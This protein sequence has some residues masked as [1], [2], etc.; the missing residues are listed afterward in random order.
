MSKILIYFPVVFFYSL[1]LA[2][3]NIYLF[4]YV[5]IYLFI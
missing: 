5:F 1:L 4:M 3:S 2:M